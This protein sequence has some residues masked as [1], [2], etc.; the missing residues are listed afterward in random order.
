MLLL[1]LSLVACVAGQGESVN[2]IFQT[3]QFNTSFGGFRQDY[4]ARYERVAS[5]EVQLENALNGVSKASVFE[6]AVQQHITLAAH[7]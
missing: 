7:H 6:T 2:P 1:L 5:G 3:S 4:C